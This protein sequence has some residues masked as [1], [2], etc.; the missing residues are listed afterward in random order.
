MGYSEYGIRARRKREFLLLC[1]IVG[2]FAGDFLTLYFK[3]GIWMF[4]C[5]MFSSLMTTFAMHGYIAQIYFNTPCKISDRKAIQVYLGSLGNNIANAIILVAGLYGYF[6]NIKD[7]SCG[8][9]ACVAVMLCVVDF[10][11]INSKV[12]LKET[13]LN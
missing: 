4:R 2:I 12:D 1:A 11:R 13:F 8:I 5:L 7:D 10:T 6:G 3:N 9:M